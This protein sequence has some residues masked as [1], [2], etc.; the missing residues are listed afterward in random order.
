[1]LGPNGELHGS[2]AKD[3]IT[4]DLEKLQA[5]NRMLGKYPASLLSRASEDWQ[6][7][8]EDFN[9]MD[10]ERPR[11]TWGLAVKKLDI[12]EEDGSFIER[13]MKH[14]PEQRPSA[15]ELLRDPWFD[16]IGGNSPLSSNSSPFAETSPSLHPAVKGPVD[17]DPAGTSPTSTPFLSSIPFLGNLFEKV[18]STPHPLAIMNA[19]KGETAE[20]TAVQDDRPGKAEGTKDDYYCVMQ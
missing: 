2:S 7:M 9:R 14:D 3:E 17:G 4:R 10:E 15:D 8:F 18:F 20:M 6:R 11:M 5:Q 12:S 19:A 1:M 16:G 13:V